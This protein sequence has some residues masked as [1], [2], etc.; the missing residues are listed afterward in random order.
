MYMDEDD[1]SY[2]EAYT[3]DSVVVSIVSPL[4]LH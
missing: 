3:P 1:H 2:F 4:I